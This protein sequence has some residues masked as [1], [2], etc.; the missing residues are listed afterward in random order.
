MFLYYLELGRVWAE[1][2]SKI[3]ETGGAGEHMLL[4]SERMC[5]QK[6]RLR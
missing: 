2:D 5:S 4:K 1:S 6:I 3:S